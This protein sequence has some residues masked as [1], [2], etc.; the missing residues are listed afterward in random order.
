MSYGINEILTY[1][2]TAS[3]T[4]MPSNSF[5]Y[6]WTFDDGGTGSASSTTHAWTTSGYHLASVTATDTT[7]SGTATA[8]K[9]VHI[10]SY[11]WSLLGQTAG[12]GPLGNGVYGVQGTK[13]LIVPGVTTTSTVVY[14]F[15]NNT[16]SAGPAL[17]LETGIYGLGFATNRFAA[18]PVRADGK[19]YIQQYGATAPQA[20]DITGNT[21][22]TLTAQAFNTF[23]D[24]YAVQGSGGD[25]YYIGMTSSFNKVYAH[26]INADTW[27]QKASTAPQA[28]L[29]HRPIHIGNNKFF[30]ITRQDGY[31]Y[32]YD[33]VADT[34]LKST[35]VCGLSL[36]SN[37][38]Y[39]SILV[40]NLV[41]S[42]GTTTLGNKKGSIY[43]ITTNTFTNTSADS[44]ERISPGLFL[45][46][47]GRIHII[48]G[49][50]TSATSTIYDPVS[51]SYSATYATTNAGASNALVH[52]IS[53]KPFAFG[54]LSSAPMY[55][56]I[57]DG[58]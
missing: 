10:M 50:T 33:S 37:A 26:N 8:S 56:D 25:A 55:A 52:P 31:G 27:A 54:A 4:G 21:T 12:P 57:F 20:V 30:T 51:D 6:A 16:F 22:T 39:T 43:N 49:S 5:T 24:Q 23:V 2:A 48:G 9:T 42:F 11:L 53:G 41:Y 1:A 47:D 32:V 17:N 38:V 13:L 29:G 35:N 45:M 34:W 58:L 14:D 15:S 44:I 19:I 7:T 36:G 28:M 40:G 3:T 18:A 46:E